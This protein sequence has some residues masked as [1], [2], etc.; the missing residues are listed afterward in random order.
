MRL[1]PN[2]ILFWVTSLVLVSTAV[3]I[4]AKNRDRN[5]RLE[6]SKPLAKPN[7]QSLE[8]H[9]VI[10]PEYPQQLRIPAA[11]NPY[12]SNKSIVLE[13]ELPEIPNR[14]RIPLEK[15]PEI[16]KL[17]KEP[18]P[19][20]YQHGGIPHE[21]EA[22]KPRGGSVKPEEAAAPRM[23][24]AKKPRRVDTY[25][26][27]EHPSNPWIDIVSKVSGLEFSGDGK[28]VYCPR[29]GWVNYIVAS[30]GRILCGYDYH[31]LFDPNKPKTYP[32]REIKKMKKELQETMSEIQEL[33][34][35]ASM[36]TES[37][38][39]RDINGGEEGVDEEEGEG[40][41]EE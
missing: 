19:L 6:Q 25:S 40:Y 2:M 17:V 16:L 11:Y 38:P 14:L 15:L 23:E 41:E 21:V 34:D 4:I 35:K 5:P 8:Y 10:I 30:D 9:D 7:P 37:S 18:Q 24:A 29:H 36:S 39:M 28:R 1:D 31:T 26:F 12:S 33:R 22:S 13:V 32:L 3:Y 27:M 20:T